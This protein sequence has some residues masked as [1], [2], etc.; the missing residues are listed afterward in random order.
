MPAQANYKARWWTPDITGLSPGSRLNTWTDALSAVAAPKA[1]TNGAVYQSGGINGAP[2]LLFDGTEYYDMGQPASLFG[3]INSATQGASVLV[4]GEAPAA[5]TAGSF[6]SASSTT[7]LNMFA[8]GS[9]AGVFGVA[10]FRYPYTSNGLVVIGMV[11]GLPEI[12]S[13]RVYINGSCVGSV[14]RIRSNQNLT[15]G[16]ASNSLINLKGRMYGCFVWDKA[17]DNFEMMQAIKCIYEEL[18]QTV[19]WA[20]TPYRIGH[21]DSITNGSGVTTQNQAWP[22]Q[23]AA[24][25]GLGFGQWSNLGMVGA[26]MGHS[27]S[28]TTFNLVD[29]APRDIDPLPHLLGTPVYV[30][31]FEWYNERNNGATTAIADAVAYVSAR[32]AAGIA[33]VVL[34][35]STDCTDGADTSTNRTE[36]K[37]YNDYWD[38]AANRMAA[39]VDQ[40]VPLHLDANIG[41]EGACPASSPFTPYFYADGIH[42]LPPAY[43]ILGA[44]SL[45]GGVGQGFGAA[46]A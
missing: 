40:Y 26:S 39:G 20:G 28:G 6:F 35:T 25:L 8:N 27:G 17:L 4:V 32:K 41:V 46:M 21:G 45:S 19:P 11:A 15:L 10:T 23:M 3:P 16:G 1:T 31:T 9:A 33:R 43:A 42:L 14:G 38:M 44:A 12:N 2:Y 37:A 34:G 29:Q 24:T 22:A 18:N 7:G 30:G 13:Q 5:T 36:R